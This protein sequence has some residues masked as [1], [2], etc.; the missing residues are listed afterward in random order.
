MNDKE[1]PLTTAA[2]YI[3]LALSECDLHGY[4]IMQSV[5]RHSQG[6]Y[7]IGPGTLYA[8]LSALL[9][10]GRVGERQRKLKN[11]DTRR[12]YSLTPSGE[13]VLRDEIRRLQRVVAAARNRLGKLNEKDA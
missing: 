3:L 1:G 12:E 6:N 9:A 4:G 13:Q 11:G 8:N 2:L 5:N 10:K 7:K